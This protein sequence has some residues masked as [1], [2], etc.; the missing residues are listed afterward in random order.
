MTSLSNLNR[1][2]F[3]IINVIPNGETNTY[4]KHVLNKCGKNDG[5]FDRS[6]GMMAYKKDSWTVY[7]CDTEN[8]MP[9]S[10]YYECD[11]INL[12]FTVNIGDLLIFKDISD[13]VPKSTK[14]FLDLRNK[15]KM[16][17]GIVTGQR[18][19]ITYDANGNPWD[20]NYIEVVKE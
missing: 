12:F 16:C 14:E 2:T 3:T 5:I 4:A 11:N 7:I 6:N 1:D 15:Y 20:T 17:G 8:Y 9:P 13:D 18:A 10:D 19:Y